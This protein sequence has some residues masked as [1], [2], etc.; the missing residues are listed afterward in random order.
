VAS[1]L[2]GVFSHG[3]RQAPGYLWYFR[4]HQLNVR[5]HV[6]IVDETETT[7]ILDGDGGLGYFPSWRAAHM[8]VEKAKSQGVG[9]AVT[10]NHGHFG[11]AG[12]YSRVASA[13]DCVGIALSGVRNP[14]VPD[15]PVM[16]AGSGSPISIAIPTG[17]EASFVPDMGLYFHYLYGSA[18]A[19]Q[20]FFPKIPDAFYKFLGLSLACQALGGTLAGINSAELKDT[21]YYEGA[22]QGSF[23]MAIDVTRFMPVAEFKRQMDAYVAGAQ[24][25]KPF[26]GQERAVLPGGLEWEREREYAKEGIPV[27]PR[28]QAEL[29]ALAKDLGMESI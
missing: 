18:S 29:N 25:M 14:L 9:V 7:A 12:H 3:T 5:P 24:K 17:E 20:E 8:V 23:I 19:L 16:E 21:R 10:R 6:G 11:A 15:R 22:N 26:P 4:N 2:R 13:A 27:S 28:H 1:D